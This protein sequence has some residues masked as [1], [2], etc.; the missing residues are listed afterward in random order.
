M[1]VPLLW[2]LWR[3]NQSYINSITDEKKM[4]K[5]EREDLFS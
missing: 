2:D 5:F 4:I 3:D 1:D